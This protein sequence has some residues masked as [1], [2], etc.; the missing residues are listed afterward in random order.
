M[1][2]RKG[3]ASAG[4]PRDFTAGKLTFQLSDR[5]AIVRGRQ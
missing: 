1:N 2:F 4:W 5:R 3:S